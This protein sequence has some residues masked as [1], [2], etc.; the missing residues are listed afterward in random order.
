MS[1][2]MDRQSAFKKVQEE[3]DAKDAAEVEK[4]LSQ[5]AVNEEYEFLMDAYLHW[6]GIGFRKGD[7]TKTLSQEDINK[8]SAT[9]HIKKV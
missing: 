8:L 2:K 1:K 3:Q 7:K 5:P 4:K 9:N 6:K